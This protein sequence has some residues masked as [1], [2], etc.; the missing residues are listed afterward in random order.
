[1]AIRTL[2]DLEAALTEDLKWRLHEIE[3]WEQLARRARTHE[4][5]G[6]L[7]G[8][9]ALLYAHWEGNIKAAARSYLEYVSRQGLKLGDLRPESW[10]R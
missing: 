4:Q 7:R 9:I 8:G 5:P 3:Q 2:D 10:P 1:M 6:L